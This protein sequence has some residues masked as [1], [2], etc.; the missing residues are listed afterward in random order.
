MQTIV[1]PNVMSATV[2]CVSL[3]AGKII[4]CK[5]FV[6]VT[7]TEASQGATSP[8]YFPLTGLPGR[9]DTGKKRG[10]IPPLGDGNEGCVSSKY[11]LGYERIFQNQ[12]RICLVFKVELLI[13][14][15]SGK[16]ESEGGRPSKRKAMFHL[17]ERH[18]DSPCASRGGEI[19]TARPMAF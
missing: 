11:Q 16:A 19:G 12:P 9:G 2:N 5:P 7:L 3:K 18:V 10:Y 8:Q 4:C 14:D 1:Q 15:K 13:G 6:S 17:S